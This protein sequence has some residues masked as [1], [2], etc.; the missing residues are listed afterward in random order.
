MQT[1]AMDSPQDPQPST[2]TRHGS[3]SS[4]LGQGNSGSHLNTKPTLLRIGEASALPVLLCGLLQKEALLQQQQHHLDQQRVFPETLNS[5]EE[6]DAQT[7]IDEEFFGLLSQRYTQMMAS[8]CR[9]ISLHDQAIP[10]AFCI[11][12]TAYNTS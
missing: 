9:S 2:L 1:V 10:S 8:A 11:E 4:A 7:A 5:F 6:N 3:R 12:R